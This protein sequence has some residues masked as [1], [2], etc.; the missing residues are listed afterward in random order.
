MLRS[1]IAIVRAAIRS[2]CH[3]DG[4]LAG[5]DQAFAPA[6]TAR[7]PPRALVL[8]VVVMAAVAAASLPLAGHAQTTETSQ[9]TADA[10]N[11]PA[12]PA[13]AAT[14]AGPAAPSSPATAEPAAPQKT[15]SAPAAEPAP[16]PPPANAAAP[17]PA[18]P[19]ASPVVEAAAAPAAP[20]TGLVRPGNLVV[21][22]FS[23][24]RLADRGADS[25]TANADAIAI[26]TDGASLRILDASAA[27]GPGADQATATR[28]VATFSARSIGQVFGVVLDDAINPATKAPAPNIYATATSAYGLNIVLP[29][30]TPD[31]WPRRSLG[32]DPSADWMAGQWGTATGADGKPVSGGPGSVWRIDGVTGDVTLFAT[33]ATDGKPNSGAGLGNIAYD[34]VSRQFFVSDLE[35]GLIHR[36]DAS[37]KDLGSFDHGVTARPAARLEPVPDDPAKRA[38]IKSAAFRADDPATWGYA[39]PSRRVWGLNVSAGRL[40]YAVADGPEIWSA[41]IAA[42]GSLGDPRREIL[43]PKDQGIF[44]ISD[45]TF[46]TNG[47]IYLA[48]RPPVTGNYDYLLLAAQAPAKVLRYRPDPATN[49]WAAVPDE[50][51]VG[52]EGERRQTD[53]GVAIG[54]GYKPTGGIDLGKCDGT[55]WT[56]GDD[57]D[58]SARSSARVNGTDVPDAGTG[59]NL[60]GLQG[61]PIDPS[62][63][64]PAS[65][66]FAD[67]DGLMPATTTRGHVGDVR[68]FKTCA[69]SS[70]VALAAATTVAEEAPIGAG[71]R[72]DLSVEKKTIGTCRIGGVCRVQVR[73]WNRGSD[74]F[75]GPLLLADTLDRAGARLISSGPSRWICGQGGA[76]TSCR[77]PQVEIRPGRSTSLFLEYR[78]PPQWSTPEFA[79]CASIGWI[80]DLT[81]TRLIYAVEIELARLGTYKGAADGVAGPLLKGAIEAYQTARNL[82]VS[83]ELTRELVEALLGSG[84]LVA[85]DADPNNDRA[86][87]SFHVDV[88]EGV[89]SY[90][91]PDVP[92]EVVEPPIISQSVEIVDEGCPDGY[93]NRGGTCVLSCPWGYAAIGDICVPVGGDRC[94]NGWFVGGTCSCP[95]GYLAERRL[96]GRTVCVASFPDRPHRC[97]GGFLSGNTCSCPSGT[98]ASPGPGGL[99]CRPIQ[100]VQCAGGLV[101]GRSCQCPAG[102]R[103]LG[104]R[105]TAN[106]PV[107]GCPIG[108]L[109]QFGRCAPIAATQSCPPGQFRQGLFCVAARPRHCPPN[110]IERNGRCL[111]LGVQAPNR[112]TRPGPIINPANCPAGTFRR[113]G[114][115][116]PIAGRPTQPPA[117]APG[118]TWN[119]RACVAPTTLP[120]QPNLPNQHGPGGVVVNCPTGTVRAGRT[121][122]PSITRPPFNP[123]RPEPHV[124]VPHVTPPPHVRVQPHV[125]RPVP[126]PRVQPAPHFQPAPHIQAP[127][128]VQPRVAPRPPAPLQPRCRKFENGHCV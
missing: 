4:R 21:T 6:R 48:E 127:R 58:R 122:V 124:V 5:S 94:S 90:V 74:T 84:I 119:G 109:R 97:F 96:G 92:V 66:H 79:D 113:G 77:H 31:G 14:S 114:N 111:A 18:E 120:R 62:A 2:A 89:A 125:L 68:V 56:T 17:S 103:L 36:L 19:A 15:E 123:H 33:I 43:I 28:E 32:G 24:T 95:D 38:D 80:G 82:P 121:C 61:G 107:V 106:A 54:Y 75:L 27:T 44:E 88:P 117:C 26:E 64:A 13:E 49:A 69:E 116:L 50:F 42:D 16:A 87:A 60:S 105:C 37:G 45:I 67:Y 101:M 52:L 1:F 99:A 8:A 126:L 110:Q 25:T 128:H 46:D 11:P 104:G 72:F 57:L 65:L 35:T 9:P 73:V 23:G 71:D 34:A 59:L 81:S 47:W 40:Y 86:C 102:T 30:A 53:G 39:H 91:A 10:A 76:E 51:A 55:L 41:A 29:P 20:A 12:S 3:S 100:P 93:W 83:G 112:P 108:T 85:G 118:L 7:R 70:G 78:L 98:V 63:E 115:C 22:G